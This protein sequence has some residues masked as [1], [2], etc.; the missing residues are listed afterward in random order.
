[1]WFFL[2]PIAHRVYGYFP[3]RRFGKVGDLPRGVMAQWRAWCLDRNYVVGVEPEARERFA[4]V[5]V[6]LVSLS[7]TDDE[8]M[9]ARNID[10][11]HAF[12]AN[13]PRTMRRIHPREAGVPRIGHFGFFRAEHAETLW[14]PELLARIES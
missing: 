4:A 2:V 14:R 9:S 12:Y 10:S 11:I 1:L 5:T 3:G 8:L 7:F 6:P 13:S